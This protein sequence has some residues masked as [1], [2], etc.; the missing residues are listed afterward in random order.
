MAKVKGKAGTSTQHSSSTPALSPS[1][2]Y[3]WKLTLLQSYLPKAM[4]NQ[5]KCY[6]KCHSG[7]ETINFLQTSLDI[8]LFFP[9]ETQFFPFCVCMC[10]YLFLG[11]PATKTVLKLKII[12]IFLAFLKKKNLI[13]Y[14]ELYHRFHV[15]LY[16]KFQ[17]T[18]FLSSVWV[19]QFW[20]ITLLH[21]ISVTYTISMYQIWTAEKL[22]VGHG[23]EL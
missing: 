21:S 22:K 19:S 10:V 14:T 3:I 17:K 8:F 12:T 7:W 23:R 1:P 11:H 5:F 2:P 6:P 4:I 9:K 13:F 15:Y 16:L 18:E 20:F